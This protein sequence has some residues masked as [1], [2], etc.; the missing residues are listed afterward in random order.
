MIINYGQQE[1]HLVP[2]THYYDPFDYSYTGIE[3]Y[4]EA[5]YIILGDVA[6]NS[7][8]EAAGLKEGDVVV[9]INKNFSQNMQLYKAALQNTGDKVNIVVRREG[10]LLVFDFKVKSIL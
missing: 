1:I 5:G 2:N 6:R 3:L 4:Y 10:E 9:A 7:P 8:A